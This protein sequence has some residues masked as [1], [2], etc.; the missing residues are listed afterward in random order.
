MVKLFLYSL[1][2][3]LILLNNES[4]AGA[5]PQKKGKSELEYKYE[6][7]ILFTYFTDPKDNSRYFSK[8][9]I[10]DLY[11]LHY[12]Y[13][14]NDKLTLVIEEKWFDFKA[15]HNIYK[16][17][18]PAFN[19]HHQ[20]ETTLKNHFHKFENNPYETKISLQRLL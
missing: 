14:I 4:L 8:A 5:W 1:F 7:K 9:F 17:D 19:F 6:N 2:S 10:L 15:K 3:I 11:S 12:Q 16:S 13:G 18:D 20:T